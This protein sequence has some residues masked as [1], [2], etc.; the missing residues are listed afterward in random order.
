M[1]CNLKSSYTE[2]NLITSENVKFI[3]ASS[4]IDNNFA[5][6]SMDED[7]KTRWESLHNLDPQWLKIEF[8][9][10][11]KISN[12]YIIW[13][14]ASAKKYEIQVSNINKNWETIA[15]V[16]DGKEGEER[17]IEFKPI[18]TKYVRVYCY[19]RTTKWGY[20]I[21]EILFNI[22]AEKPSSISNLDSC[23]FRNPNL[24]IELRV[25]D[26]LKRMTLLEKIEQIS[27]INN[28]DCIENQRLKI[29]P[30]LMADG[31][32]GIRGYGPATC[33]PTLIACATWDVNL[34][35]EVGIAIAK[36]ARAK[37]RNI[38]LGPCINIHRTPLGGRN[39]ESLS[40]DPYLASRMAVAYIK[41]VNSQ[42]IGTAVKHF[43]CNNQ[44]F[45]RNT[46]SVEISERALREI[47]LPAFKASVCKAGSIGIMAAYNK[48]NGEYCCENYHL[49]TEILR[50]EWN[51]KGFVVSDWGAIH[52]T[53]NA[54]NAGCDIEMPGPAHF[55][56]KI[57]IL[58]ALSKGLI[59]EKT[60]DEKVKRILYT[61][62]SLGLFDDVSKKFKGEANT[63]KHQKLAREIAEN[64]IVLLKNENRTLPLNVKKI[65]TL[66][67]IGQLAKYVTIDGAGSSE[68]KT[69]Y[70]IQPFDAIIEKCLKY[71]ITV[72]YSPGYFIPEEINIIPSTV[73][74]T[75]YSNNFFQGLKA[76]YYN[77]IN[78]EGEP[79]SIKINE[80]VNFNWRWK[81]PV[82][83]LNRDNFSIRWTGK[84]LPPK[85]G[86]YYFYLISDDGSRLYI[87]ENLI[88]DNWGE[89]GP[90][91][92]TGKIFL[93]NSEEYDIKIEFYE[94][95]GGA[96]IKLGWQIPD[97]SL[98]SEA[99]K[100]ANES[101][102]VIIFAGLYKN[103]ETEGNDRK[104]MSLP[105]GQE[106]IIKEVSKVNP[107]IIVVLINGSPVDIKNWVNDVPSIIEAFYPG[108]EAGNAIVSVLFGDVNPSGKLPFTF[109]LKL[110]DNP[111][112]ENYPGENGKVFYAEDIFVGYR[113]YDT[114]NIKPLF[115]FGHGLSY[116]EFKYSNLKLSSDYLK[117][118]KNLNIKLEVKNIGNY[119][120][121][122]VVQ[123]YV[124]HISPSIPKP[125][126]ELKGFKKIFLRKGEKK[127]VRFELTQEDFSFYHPDRKKWVVEPGEYEILIGSSSR[128][129]RLRKKFKLVD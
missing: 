92:K 31:P 116:T 105:E 19:E 86:E 29:P 100:V 78:F 20:S 5:K 119:D 109:P 30:L 77:N 10:I 120:G 48:I 34:M 82:E 45:E 93:K 7:I 26:L 94:K 126:K 63:E 33:F 90:L 124:H 35:K 67:I 16:E 97:I 108:Q 57:N 88:I 14:Y 71:N 87:N 89:H 104:D 56:S 110:E 11:Y 61:K 23:P 64:G 96:M 1:I 60:L 62:F 17:I 28:M 99:I 15:V 41:G 42:K 75:Y 122:E 84:L 106:E 32:H 66:G 117:I 21:Y 4:E 58:K 128:D 103:F 8:N 68:V 55:F 59:T 46:I 25:E 38:V 80:S 44:E 81:S 40:E 129:I 95:E 50:N 125:Y 27:G 65:K 123:L 114:K 36:E 9:N 107:N 51:F 102:Y 47:Y 24:P 54:F 70:V 91:L 98:K 2:V 113:Y 49:L 74:K 3:S 101:D 52:N 115:P 112:Y 127:I 72:K 73:F 6:Y 111:T 79:V 83:N 69:P 12:I 43:A 53:V 118:G 39:F 76:E 85:T 22:P 18:A 37:G 121:K 13:E